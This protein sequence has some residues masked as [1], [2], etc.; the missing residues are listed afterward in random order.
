ME[1]SQELFELLTSSA[2]PL[3]GPLPPPT[4]CA[5]A[6][7][8]AP[9]SQLIP[10]EKYAAEVNRMLRYAVGGGE[11]HVDTPLFDDHDTLV[12]THQILMRLYY[13]T[14]AAPQNT[15]DELLCEILKK[16]DV[17]RCLADKSTRHVAKTILRLMR[18]CRVRLRRLNQSP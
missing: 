1:P 14:R 17:V 12:D 4:V 15:H 10:I 11:T 7:D 9:T 3:P 18:E 6:T 8:V 16:V 5:A 13:L 2:Q